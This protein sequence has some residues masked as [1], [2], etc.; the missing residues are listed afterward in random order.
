MKLSIFT[1]EGKS[2][3]DEIDYM[4]IH[5]EDGEVAILKDHIPIIIQIQSGYLKCV[6]GNHLKYAIIE[7]GILEFKDNNLSVLALDA[8]VGDT[9]EN[10]KVSFEKMK[11]DK[12][13]MTKKE[14][15]DL[16]K[17]ER[18]LKENIQK[19]KAGQL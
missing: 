6:M 7:Q 1:A 8:E 15:I 10:T 13:E 16:S 5:N 17:Q 11:K 4:V 9:L 18:E 12:L 3:N 19:S 2:F 14:N